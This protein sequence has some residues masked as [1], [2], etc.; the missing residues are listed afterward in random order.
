MM[1]AVAVVAVSVAS[2]KV[3]REL[4]YWTL[5]YGWNTSVF[6]AGTRVRVYNDMVSGGLTIA[7]GTKCVVVSDPP[8]EDSAYPYRDVGVRVSEGL[9]TGLALSV[10][11]INLRA[12]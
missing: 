10:D 11:R 5:S 9:H 8:D 3:A 1:V 4:N 7:A 6:P 2:A 12:E